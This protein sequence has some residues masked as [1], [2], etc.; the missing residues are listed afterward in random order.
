MKRRRTAFLT[1]E[2]STLYTLGIVSTPDRDI[3]KIGSAFYEVCSLKVLVSIEILIFV[4]PPNA[5]VC[6]A[7]PNITTKGYEDRHTPI[8]MIR[9]SSIEEKLA[10][11]QAH[12]FTMGVI[13]QCLV[14]VRLVT[15]VT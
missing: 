14:F 10:M 12:T 13:Y 15:V 7:Y 6:Y 4:V 2:T 1:Y 8:D 9:K 3:D 5:A 11:E